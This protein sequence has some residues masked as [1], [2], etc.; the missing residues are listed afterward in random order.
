MD[1]LF[2][3][4]KSN[5]NKLFK[6]IS[7]KLMDLKMQKIGN[8]K[9]NITHLKLILKKMIYEIMSLFKLFIHFFLFLSVFF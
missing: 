4:L 9:Y 6:I 5:Y 1:L 7:K 3:V 8:L 2:A